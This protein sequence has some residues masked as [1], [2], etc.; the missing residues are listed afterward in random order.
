MQGA[1]KKAKKGGQFSSSAGSRPTQV[2][3][4]NFANTTDQVIIS[5]PQK[6]ADIMNLS[7]RP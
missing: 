3:P 6:W 7:I 5:W 1:S 4:V 2:E